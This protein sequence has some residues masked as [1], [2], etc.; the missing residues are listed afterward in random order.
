MSTNFNTVNLHNAQNQV[1]Y[2]LTISSHVNVPVQALFLPILYCLRYF[3]FLIF[4]NT[5]CSFLFF[6]PTP[7][8]PVCVLLLHL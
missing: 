6:F 4:D 7:V 1:G 5:L 3:A 8:L 2:V